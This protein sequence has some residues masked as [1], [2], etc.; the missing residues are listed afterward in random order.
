M[1]K[2]TA[3]LIYCALLKVY[4]L[5]KHLLMEYFDVPEGQQF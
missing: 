3:G 2:F 4:P 1:R 5:E